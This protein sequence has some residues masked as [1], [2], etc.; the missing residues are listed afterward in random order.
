MKQEVDLRIG[1][2]GAN[3]R[4]ALFQLQT[5]SKAIEELEPPP[6]RFFSENEKLKGHPLYNLKMSIYWL[7]QIEFGWREE[8]YN[9]MTIE[10]KVTL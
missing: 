4:D 10:T 1:S 3:L 6:K 2:Q 9:D 5:I 8:K 7:R